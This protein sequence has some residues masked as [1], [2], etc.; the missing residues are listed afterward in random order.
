MW[1]TGGG[2]LVGT[3]EEEWIGKDRKRR[4]GGEEEGGGKAIWGFCPRLFRAPSEQRET[5]HGPNLDGLTRTERLV[6]SWRKK[7]W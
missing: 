3:L 6:G 2:A 4:E 1:R 5:A 7:M